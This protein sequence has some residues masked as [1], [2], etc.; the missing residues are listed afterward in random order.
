MD[1]LKRENKIDKKFWKAKMG[2]QER[3][4]KILKTQKPIF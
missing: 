2:G 1:G 3:E 4:N